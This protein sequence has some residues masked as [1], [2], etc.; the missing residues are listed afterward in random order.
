MLILGVAVGEKKAKPYKH[1]ILSRYYWGGWSNGKPYGKG[2][3][4]TDVPNKK[5]YY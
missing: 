5:M 3:F 1:S 4:Y 2:I